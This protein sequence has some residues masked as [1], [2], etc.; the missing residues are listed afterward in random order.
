MEVEVNTNA[1]K[2]FQVRLWPKITV[3][4][5]GPHHR[6]GEELDALLLDY[7]RFISFA[8]EFKMF[9]EATLFKATKPFYI[10]KEGVRYYAVVKR[11]A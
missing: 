9:A 6:R 11:I 8:P 1:A 2:M 5:K 4:G 10:T 3:E 7:N